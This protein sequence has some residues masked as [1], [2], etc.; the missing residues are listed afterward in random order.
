MAVGKLRWILDVGGR[1]AAGEVIPP[2]TDT[3]G[4][5]GWLEDSM[6]VRVILERCLGPCKEAVL[7]DARYKAL[8]DECRM[9]DRVETI[10]KCLVEL[11]SVRLP[12][13]SACGLGERS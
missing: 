13:F 11:N 10:R 9:L 8:G 1:A 4:Y 6:S 2:V 7:K 12:Q 3:D 5:V